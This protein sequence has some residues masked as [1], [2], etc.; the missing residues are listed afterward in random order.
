MK[1]L[2]CSLT[3]PLPNGVSVSINRSID[4]FKKKG[5]ETLVISPDYK[6]GQAREEHRIVPSSMIAKGA[7][8]LIGKEERIF[9]FGA[10]SKIE[11]I[12]REFKPDAY[13][14]H[15]ITFTPNAF[16]RF[17]F[18]S[19]KPKVVT[20]HTMVEEYGRIYAGLVGAKTMRIRSK[21]VCNNADAVIIPSQMMKDRVSEYVTTPI[22]VIPTGIVIP[23]DQ[24]SRDEICER[25]KIDS[26]SKLLLYVGRISKEKNLEFLLEALKRVNRA[27]M[28]AT[29]LFV[30][31]G[32]LDEMREI[33]QEMGIGS[34]T[35][36]TGGLAKEEAQRIYGGADLFVF[37][38]QTETQ[39]L[40]IGE[41]MAAE[42]PVF[43]LKSPIQKEVYPEEVA[44][45][46][47]DLTE[48]VEKLIETLNNLEG[49]KKMVERA[50]TFVDDNFSE[51]L[52]IEKQIKVFERLIDRS[53]EK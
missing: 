14:L 39:G 42:T 15:T 50:K 32:D 10:Y 44:I 1:I 37:S 6:V 48:F 12:D 4:G 28:D 35:V 18:K 13:W 21:S 34:K 49:T 7:A 11:E 46:S 45:I 23:K 30:G 29:L 36:F 19:R 53:P 27:K 25:F 20:Y 8:I 47:S 38:S 26:K 24:F 52:M 31:P 33:A 9:G 17:I 43:A 16:E 51:E 40:V 3:Y 22:E 41:A 2:I 5:V